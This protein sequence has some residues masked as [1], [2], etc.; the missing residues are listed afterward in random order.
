MRTVVGNNR[1]LCLC[2]FFLNLFDF[3]LGHV[4]CGKNEINIVCNSLYIIDVPDHDVLHILR[5]LSVQL[6]SSVNRFAVSMSC[7]AGTCCNFR[8][9]KPG[10]IL[11]NLNETL[12][13]HA[14]S[15]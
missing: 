5:N 15:T 6:P 14:G 2:I 7:A 3:I 8:N 4:H 13:N 1:R 12:A 10:M 11:K 9:L